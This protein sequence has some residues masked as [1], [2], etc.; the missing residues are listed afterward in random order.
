M[1]SPLRKILPLLAAGCGLAVSA[2]ACSIYLGGPEAPGPEITPAGDEASIEKAW[3]DAAA[4]SAEGTV[5]VVFNEAQMTAY[6]QRKLDVRPDNNFHTAQVYL[7]DGRIKVYGVL[8]AGSVSASAIIILRPDVTP[9]G[10]IDLV[11]EQAQVGPLDLPTG[12]LTAISD[13][14]TEVFTGSIGSLA[15]GFQVKEVLVGDGQIAISGVL[16]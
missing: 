15:T 3:A 8:T 10:K 13:V 4:F 16:R 5:T 11:M 9:Q 1:K 6:L 12:L 2:L 7:R 14:L